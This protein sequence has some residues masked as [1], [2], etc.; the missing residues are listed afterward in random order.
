[1]AVERYWQVEDYLNMRD[2]ILAQAEYHNHEI[3]FRQFKGYAVSNEAGAVIE[4]FRTP[5]FYTLGTNAWL[6]PVKVFD[7]VKGGYFTTGDLQCQSTFQIQGYSPAYVLDDGTKINEYAG[8]QVIWNGKVWLVA[9]QI[10]PRIAG[11][12]AQPVLYNTTLRR[13]DRSSQGVTAGAK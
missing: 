13:V 7:T 3:V 2:G 10:D 12:M 4:Q 9:D 1:M 5:L 8:D 11:F 6:A